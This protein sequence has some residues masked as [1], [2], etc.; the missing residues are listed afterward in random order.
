MS[1]NGQER[2][3][4]ENEAGFRSEDL[5]SSPMMVHLMDALKSGQDIGH[6]GRLTFV[7]IARHF[8]PD[9]ELV[10]LLLGQPGMDERE[11][12]TLVAQVNARGYNPPSRERI[13]EWQEMQGF[14]ICPDAEDPNACNV[15]RELQFPDEIYENINDFWEEKVEADE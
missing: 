14:P 12:R 9:D 1:K 5:N 3:N 6:Y 11:A 13:L 8:L 4:P 15:Y 10:K 7:M 2:S